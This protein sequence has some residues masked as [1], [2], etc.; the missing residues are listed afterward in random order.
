MAR[1][2]RKPELLTMVGLSDATVWRMERAGKFPRRVQLGGNSVG[3]LD[4][5]V[6]NW[7]S[8]KAAERAA[9]AISLEQ[10]GDHEPGN[11]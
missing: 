3:W 7:F 5:E 10:R 11:H 1:I 4:S 2:I 6:E 8:A 9:P